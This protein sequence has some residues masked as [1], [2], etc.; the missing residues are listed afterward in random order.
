MDQRTVVRVLPGHLES[1]RARIIGLMLDDEQGRQRI[2]ERKK[3]RKVAQE[4]KD[5]TA[6]EAAG[7]P[8]FQPVTEG[9]QETTPAAGAG[10]STEQARPLDASGL[11]LSRL[12]TMVKN[13]LEGKL[14]ELTRRM[15]WTSRTTSSINHH[16]QTESPPCTDRPTQCF[17]TSTLRTCC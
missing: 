13:M 4:D 12:K 15:R 16:S 8:L 9:R 5:V 11:S 2:E 1:C 17:R 7:E 10:V 6:E 3:K 14:N